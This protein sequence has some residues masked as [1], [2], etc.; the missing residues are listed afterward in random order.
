MLLRATVIIAE[1]YYHPELRLLLRQTRNK[2][3]DKNFQREKRIFKEYYQ[4]YYTINHQTFATSN[5]V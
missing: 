5:L 1:D 2:Q 3:V 4:L